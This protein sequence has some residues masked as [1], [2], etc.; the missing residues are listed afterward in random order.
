MML[1]QEQK[2]K[3]KKGIAW[4]IE[5]YKY[6]NFATCTR[7][8]VKLSPRIHLCDCHDSQFL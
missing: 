2:K 5:K 3:E 4:N 8:L 1:T 7:Y 6:Q